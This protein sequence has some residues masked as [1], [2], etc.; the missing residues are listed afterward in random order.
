PGRVYVAPPDNHLLVERERVRVIH[1]PRENRY[2]PAVD[3]LFRSAAVAYGPRVVGVVLTGALDD[4]TI[5]MVAVKKCGG[6]AVVQ[7]PHEAIYGGMPSSVMRNVKVDYCV[8]LAKIAPLLA[9]LSREPAD[10]GA[11]TL[12]GDFEME[13]KIAEQE[14]SPDE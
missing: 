4:G 6:V 11:Y 2:R 10:E 13:N 12:D 14:M 1:G 7:D 5:G 9:Q 8:R 3:P